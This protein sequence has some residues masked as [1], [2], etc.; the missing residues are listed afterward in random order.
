LDREKLDKE[1]LNKEKLNKEKLNKE[2]LNKEKLNK[3][4]LNKER[5]NGGNYRKTLSSLVK[6]GKQLLRRCPCVLLGPL[7]SAHKQLSFNFA[8]KEG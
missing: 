7:G 3:E 4:K 5:R 6:K 1:K 2:K 8:N